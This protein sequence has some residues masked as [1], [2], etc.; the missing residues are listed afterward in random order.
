[1]I[2]L[3]HGQGLREEGAGLAAHHVIATREES[4]VLLSS[5]QTNVDRMEALTIACDSCKTMRQFFEAAHIN[6][7][8]N[9]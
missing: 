9:L 8:K 1:M 7:N 6:N 2:E 3:W 4:V 5:T